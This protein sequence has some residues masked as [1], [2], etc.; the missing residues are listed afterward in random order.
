MRREEAILSILEQAVSGTDK[1]I[2]TDKERKDFAQHAA[3]ILGDNDNAFVIVEYFL[4][5]WWDTDKPCRRCSVCGKLMREGYHCGSTRQYYCSDNCL[6][7]D[8][9]A[10]EW[11][12]ECTD[13]SQS[14]YTEW[15]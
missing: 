5:F 3:R 1:E 4:D 7:R 13:D 15:Y 14:Y 2:Y 12:K 9:S 10:E 6:H 8:F 11:E